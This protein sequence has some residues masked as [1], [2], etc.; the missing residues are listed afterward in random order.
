MDQPAGTISPES[1]Q[2][3]TP[4]IDDEN[5]AEVSSQAVAT[6]IEAASRRVAALLPHRQGAVMREGDLSGAPLRDFSIALE[7][8]S[9]VA[10]QLQVD[11]EELAAVLKRAEV[12]LR[13]YRELY[14]LAPCGSLVT[15]AHGPIVVANEPTRA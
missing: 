15:D 5:S 1:H 2:T 4:G 11:N 7:L 9:S 12:D 3:S 14:L 10:D 6:Q 8:V 13:H